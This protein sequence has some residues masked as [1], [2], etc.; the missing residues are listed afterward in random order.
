MCSS[1]VTA[2][3][4]AGTTSPISLFLFPVTFAN[5]LFSVLAP[6]KFFNSGEAQLG[7]GQQA[8]EEYTSSDVE[9]ACPII[10]LLDSD[11]KGDSDIEIE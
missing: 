8:S 4:L 5:N 7:R 6:R 9:E 1:V 3:N 10:Q 2:E 11:H